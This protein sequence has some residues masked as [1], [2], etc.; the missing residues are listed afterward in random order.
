MILSQSQIAQVV[1]YARQEPLRMSSIEWLCDLNNTEREL[2]V[3]GALPHC[4][5]FNEDPKT[6]TRLVRQVWAALKAEEERVTVLLGL[7]ACPL[8]MEEEVDGECVNA[9]CELGRSQHLPR[10]F[11]R[12]YSA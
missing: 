5:P 11:A 6:W 2:I 1:A 10:T 7:G 12:K 8:C 4:D 3:S 9:V